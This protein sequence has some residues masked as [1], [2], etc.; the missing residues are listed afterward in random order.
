MA[1]AFFKLARA[2]PEQAFTVGILLSKGELASRAS[3]TVAGSPV[4]A[5][6]QHQLLGLLCDKLLRL[7]KVD[8]LRDVLQLCLRLNECGRQD[9]VAETETVVE[10]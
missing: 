1:G 7:K 3:S 6:V 5:N 10:A 8:K 4:A 2:Q 9:N